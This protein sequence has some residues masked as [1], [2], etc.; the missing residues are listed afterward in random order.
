MLFGFNRITCLIQVCIAQ[1][2][3][4]NI[5]LIF[6]FVGIVLFNLPSNVRY[7]YGENVISMQC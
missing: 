3:Q 7:S 5:F 4:I 6:Q 1:S 2:M